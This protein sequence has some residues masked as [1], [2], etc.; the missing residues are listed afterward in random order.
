MAFLVIASCSDQIITQTDADESEIRQETLESLTSSS[1]ERPLR[2][3]GL[4]NGSKLNNLIREILIDQGQ[5]P[6]K[7]RFGELSEKGYSLKGKEAWDKYMKDWKHGKGKAASGDFLL[8]EAELPITSFSSLPPTPAE[9]ELNV[10]D[11]SSPPANGSITISYEGKQVQ[12]QYNSSQTATTVAYAIYSN[13]N[14]SPDIQLTAA[15]PSPGTL[16]LT[17]KRDGCDYN[18]NMV[19]VS[20]S[21]GTHIGLNSDTFVMRGGEDVE[22]CQDPVISPPPGDPDILISWGSVIN[23]P[24]FDYGWVDMW[25]YSWASEPVYYLDVI[26][27]SQRDFIIISSGQDGGNNRSYAIVG[28]SEDKQPLDPESFWQ[29]SG[30]HYFGFSADEWYWGVSQ[31][32]LTY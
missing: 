23:T 14:Q 6:D 22:G 3:P 7:I 11:L 8:L 21:Q 25:S 5:D 26:G 18:G 28:A 24:P 29:Q 27:V 12:T 30:D 17:E 20:E 15:V 1:D 31:K 9:T 10:L 4:I 32:R 2:E 19:A 16:V 13:I